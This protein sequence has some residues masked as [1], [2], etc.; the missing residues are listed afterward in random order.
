MKNQTCRVFGSTAWNKLRKHIQYRQVCYHR[1]DHNETIGSYW[2]PLRAFYLRYTDA[3]HSAILRLKSVSSYCTVASELHKPVQRFSKC[4]G[5]FP[6]LDMPLFFV[7]NA[8][9]STGRKS[10]H[11]AW[12]LAQY[13]LHSIQLLQRAAISPL[14]ILFSPSYWDFYDRFTCDLEEQFSDNESTRNGVVK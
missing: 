13:A 9:S 2:E 5:C 14:L 10:R 12:L 11:H 7:I 3:R 1:I 4:V 8:L 6:L